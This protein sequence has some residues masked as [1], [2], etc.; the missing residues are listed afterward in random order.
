M[1]KCFPKCLFLA[2]LGGPCK[3]DAGVGEPSACI[4]W[5]AEGDVTEKGIRQNHHH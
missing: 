2:G 3:M 4:L 5:G 1:Q